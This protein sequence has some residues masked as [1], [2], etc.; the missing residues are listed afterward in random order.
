M[1]RECQ[2]VRLHG[3]QY[4]PI[5]CPICCCIRVQIEDL[6]KQ[7]RTKG[8]HRKKNIYP[9]FKVVSGFKL[10]LLENVSNLIRKTP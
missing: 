2:V 8:G 3:S 7:K 5:A 1:W 9:Y 4:I 10:D 6:E